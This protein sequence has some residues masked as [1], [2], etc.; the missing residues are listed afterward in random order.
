MKRWGEGV[1]AVSQS[2]QH[3]SM[4]QQAYN[5]RRHHGRL[6]FILHIINVIWSRKSQA[7]LKESSD[8]ALQDK[9]G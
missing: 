7:A 1:W 5:W 2:E 9:T 4:H 6:R 3:D 8:S